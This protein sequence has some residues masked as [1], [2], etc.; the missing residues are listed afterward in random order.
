M[1]EIEYELTYLA[2]QIPTEINGVKPTRV[3]DI[4]LPENSPNH[5]H[6]RIRAKGDKYELTKKEPIEGTDS[7]VQTE[8]TIALSADEYADLS[9]NRTR[10]VSKDRYKVTIANRPAEVDVFCNELKGLVLID[11][12]FKTREEQLAFTMP[13]VCLVDVT[14]EAFIAGGILAGKSYAD[15]EPF[16]AKYNYIK[17]S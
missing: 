15:I 12:E 13:D 7:S 14:Q 17:L 10:S 1:V 9:A 4:Y 16:L 2:K 11:F 6:M 5:P 8:H 3:T